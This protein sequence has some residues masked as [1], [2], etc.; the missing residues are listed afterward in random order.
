MA[1]LYKYNN[2][3][4]PDELVDEDFLKNIDSRLVFWADREQDISETLENLNYAKHAGKAVYVYVYKCDNKRHLYVLF[5]SRVSGIVPAG[6][7]SYRV[8]ED[9]LVHKGLV[10][11]KVG[12]YISCYVKNIE[13]KNSK[14]GDEYLVTLSRKDVV[15]K[16]RNRYYNDLK[17]GMILEGVVVGLTPTEAII[18]IG[19][20]VVGILGVR[21]IARVYI[22]SPDEVL[23]LNQKLLVMVD[24]VIKGQDGSVRYE[25][26]RKKLLPPFSEIHKRYKVGDI[27]LGTVKG[28][29]GT[30]YFIKLDEFYEG[31]AKFV[32]NRRYKKGDSVK[33]LI[34]K[35]DVPRERINLAIKQ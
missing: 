3:T 12:A 11:N 30:G 23:S 9:G 21:N 27:V 28:S 24:K 18:D 6:E 20:D 35:I 26:S 7:V 4:I 19:G 31:V 2:Q 1:G 29:M 8:M 14:Y 10:I 33:V 16:V 22:D 34:K 32:S 17:R 25:F 5:G 13:K 15:E